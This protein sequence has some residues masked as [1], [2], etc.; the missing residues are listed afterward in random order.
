M[1]YFLS[2]KALCLIIFILRMSVQVRADFF[3]PACD[4][5]SP[6]FQFHNGINGD[7]ITYVFILRMFIEIFN[8]WQT[9]EDFITENLD[10]NETS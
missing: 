9:C 7:S 4:I 8:Y 2:E 10:N 3:N 5:T 6:D 1:N